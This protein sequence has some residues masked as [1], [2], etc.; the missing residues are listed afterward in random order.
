MTAVHADGSCD[1]TYTDGVVE[2]GV[3]PAYVKALSSVDVASPNVAG[4]PRVHAAAS[5]V[6]ATAALPHM[7]DQA[8]AAALHSAASSAA[9]RV[10]QSCEYVIPRQAAVVAGAS[11]TA[12]TAAK[13]VRPTELALASSS[14]SGAL[15]TLNLR[16][17]TAQRLA[18]ELRAAPEFFYAE[19]YH[20]QYLAKNPGG[21]CGIGG[22]GITCPVGVIAS[23]PVS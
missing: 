18:T 5:G 8:C 7:L 15:Q 16:L 20:Q 3:L 11:L 6:H 4:P 13:P 10:L 22:T 1:V 9:E 2:H 23:D 12:P 21:Y 14:S 17:C 19:D